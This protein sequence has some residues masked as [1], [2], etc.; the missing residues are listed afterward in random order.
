MNSQRRTR[1]AQV[2]PPSD[3]ITEEL[4]ARGWTI[5]DLAVFSGRSVRALERVI[6]ENKPL[7][8]EIAA[9]LGKAFGTSS[10][11]WR[12]L[13][14]A[15]RSRIGQQSKRRPVAVIPRAPSVAR[16]SKRAL[17]KGRAAKGAKSGK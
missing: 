8:R 4:E 10:E 16:Q 3:F 5:E 15:Y 9:G 14:S 6:E 2:F 11:L 1:L 7:T 17:R 13:E 12:N